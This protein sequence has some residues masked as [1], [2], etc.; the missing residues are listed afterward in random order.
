MHLVHYILSLSNLL[1]IYPVYY[2]S[3]FSIRWITSLIMF[4]STMMHLSEIKHGLQPSIPFFNQYSLWFLNLD[5]L[6]TVC[7]VLYFIPMWWYH[8][9]CDLI[10]TIFMLAL[11]I[12][13]ISEQSIDLFTYTLGHL[14]WHMM[15]YLLLSMF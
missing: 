10:V 15:I 11:L 14:F 1:G 6:V 8:H 2:S 7:S 3:H 9:D 4:A 5:R 12:G 13:W